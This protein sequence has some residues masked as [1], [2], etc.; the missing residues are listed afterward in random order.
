MK[1]CRW[2]CLWPLSIRPR[3]ASYHETLFP[4]SFHVFLSP[5]TLPLSPS[6]PR[7][8]FYFSRYRRHFRRQPLGS[9]IL[10]LYGNAV[11]GAR[12]VS[13]R[14]FEEASRNGNHRT[15]ITF[16]GN[17]GPLLVVDAFNCFSFLL[18]LPPPPLPVFFSHF[19]P[20]RVLFGSQMNL[21]S[22]K[23]AIH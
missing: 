14:Y 18:L 2:M 12:A 21:R 7:S 19:F 17:S 10:M 11:G 23:A 13:Y 3:L 22:D 4:L 9:G 5:D 15:F 6:C 1:N 20:H 16:V 8:F